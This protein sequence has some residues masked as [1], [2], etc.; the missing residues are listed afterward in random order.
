MNI[1]LFEEFPPQNLIPSGD[2]RSHHIANILKLGVGDKFKVCLING[3]AGVCRVTALTSEGI[4]FDFEAQEEAKELLDLTLLIAQVRPICMKRILRDATM[5]GV[6]R[7]ITFTSDT[8]ER[9]YAKSK[10]WSSG[11]YYKYKV[12]GAMQSGETGMGELLLEDNLKSVLDKYKWEGR[13]VLDVGE[14][15]PSLATIEELSTPSVLAIGPERG[16][17]EAERDLFRERGFQFRSMGRRILR[18]ETAS[19]TA[20]ILLLG[21]LGHL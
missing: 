2:Y 21:K 4:S 17:S 14:E 5:I 1:I 19:A 16:W 11:E 7:I 9:S 15:H 10:L 13:V 6:G 3:V 8:T 12:D 20:L 18:S